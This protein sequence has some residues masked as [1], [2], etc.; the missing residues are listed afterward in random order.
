MVKYQRKNAMLW[1]L[2]FR[3]GIVKRDKQV[4]VCDSLLRKRY[5]SKVFSA[6]IRTYKSE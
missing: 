3:E 1:T 5:N 4:F 2:I 6:Y